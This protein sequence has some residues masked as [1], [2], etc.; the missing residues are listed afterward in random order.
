MPA[1]DRIRRP[2]CPIEPA[3][4]LRPAWGAAGLVSLFALLASSV[5]G[6][7]GEV[8]PL[9]SHDC[10]ESPPASFPES[11]GA[12]LARVW[13]SGADGLPPKAACMAHGP[14][15]SELWISVAARSTSAASADVLLARFG[16]ISQLRQVKYWSIT[17]HLW[18]PLF[19]SATA[20]AQATGG[21]RGDFSLDEL[22]RGSPL[23]FEQ[24]D[25]RSSRKVVYE[26]RLLHADG[27]GFVISTVNV[28]PVQ[29]WGVSLYKSGELQTLYF[30]EHMAGDEWRFYSLS[31]VAG[32]HLF[33]AQDGS[34]INRTVA[35]YRFFLGI[36]TDTE[37]PAAP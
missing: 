34:Y 30:L 9:L 10:A 27:Q 2:R 5:P 1:G 7:S 32:S 20:L 19:A 22:K 36:P 17:D 16:L 12:P 33:N 8:T 6:A 28:S 29:W 24:A 37:P 35:L 23:Y 18:R 13:K 26:L 31:R 21:E 4:R 3:E 15:G 11:G 14:A 25:S